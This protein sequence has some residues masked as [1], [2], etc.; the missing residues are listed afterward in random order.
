MELGATVL[1]VS[2][3]KE[4]LDT[5]QK[6]GGSKIVV[7]QVDLINWVDTQE[8]LK[9]WACKVDLL[10]NNAALSD[11]IEIGDIDEKSID[12]MFNVN[13]KACLNLI[14]MLAPAMKAR[15][16][17]SIVNVSSVSG[18]AAFTGHCVYGSTKSA[19]D[20][21]TKI[22]AKEL[23][24]HGIRVNSVNPTVVWTDMGKQFWQEEEK[25]REMMS[26]IP[27]GRFVS[28]DECVYPIIFLLSDYASMIN[29]VLLPIDG[30]FTAT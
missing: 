28:V 19:L 2:R 29:G 17:G 12:D 27:A 14:Q 5:L 26:K 8:R 7:C 13:Y 20:M 23:G 16:S 15:K 3:S 18:M 9:E 21:L 4:T 22:S 30:G 25:K 6:E 10:V 1:A 24:P 11:H